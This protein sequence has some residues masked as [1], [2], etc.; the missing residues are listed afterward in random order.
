MLW[1]TSPDTALHC[2]LDL[3]RMGTVA[4]NVAGR[5][6]KRGRGGREWPSWAIWSVLA[7]IGL[8][9]GVAVYALSQTEDRHKVHWHQKFQVV[10]QGQNVSFVNST[11]LYLRTGQ[12]TR[13]TLESAHLHSPQFE[14]VHNEGWA[15]RTTW[16]EFF[17]L[18]LK[19]TIASDKLVLPEE[20]QAP[21]EYVAAGDVKLQYFVSNSDRDDGWSTLPDAAERTL[22]EHDTMLVVYGNYTA[23][24][25]A[26][27][28]AKAPFF[29]EGEIP[30]DMMTRITPR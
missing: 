20:S 16:G 2:R 11:F 18:T 15:N 8:V 23:A 12:F 22:F 7:A 14:I 29:A 10:V 9:V 6:E 27:L 24:E 25:I 17:L 21:G 4:M 1:W 19:T 28:Q 3:W 30:I 13:S 5:K 26:D